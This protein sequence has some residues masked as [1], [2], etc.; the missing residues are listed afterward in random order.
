MPIRNIE[1]KCKHDQ[2]ELVEKLLLELNARYIGTDQQTDTYFKTISG[3]LKLREG[4]IE[5][6]LI[7]YDR[8]ENKEF[9]DSKIYLLH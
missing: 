8:I 7:F 1:I 6:N 4:N 5:N 9:K 2:P 3:R